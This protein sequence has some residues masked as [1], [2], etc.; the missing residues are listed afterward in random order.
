MPGH[1]LWL[2]YY[3]GSTAGTICWGRLGRQAAQMPGWEMTFPGSGLWAA[4][5][6]ACSSR[7]LGGHLPDICWQLCAQGH[8][9]LFGVKRGV[10]VGSIGFGRGKC[11][12]SSSRL[13][14]CHLLWDILS[15][16][17]LN[18]LPAQPHFVSVS[19][20]GVAQQEEL[21]NDSCLCR[22]SMPNSSPNPWE[23]A[24]SLFCGCGERAS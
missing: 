14:L 5:E 15:Q 3:I 21:S 8:V 22:V 6:P 2:C 23:K 13:L 18:F 10:L 20:A 11:Q 24:S 1:P 7:A 16:H 12:S 17:K 4:A 9:V 19:K